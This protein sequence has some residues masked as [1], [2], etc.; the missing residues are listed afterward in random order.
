MKQR[1]LDESIVEREGLNDCR[2]LLGTF[3]E[4]FER[5]YA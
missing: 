5:D 1:V 4:L 3:F 2:I